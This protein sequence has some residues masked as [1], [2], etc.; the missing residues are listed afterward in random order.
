MIGFRLS[1]DWSVHRT[2]AGV[3]LSGG[4]DALFQVE[5]AEF[6]DRLVADEAVERPSVRGSEAGL[7]E[8]L[9]AAEIVI[10]AIRV[11]TSGAVALVG[12]QPP[13]EVRLSEGLRRVEGTEEA[14]LVV[15]VRRTCSLWMIAELTSRLEQLHL[16]VDLSFHH[17]VSIGPLVVPHQ[18]ACISCLAGRVTERWGESEPSADP[19]VA[20]NYPQLSAALVATE[21]ERA[22]AGDGSLVG[23]TASWNLADRTARRERLLTTAACPYC[24]P[25]Q[26]SGRIKL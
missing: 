11:G 4:D 24:R 6:L 1:P 22:I 5:A 21:I 8:K 20:R 16:F 9:V 17:T 12:D 13:W 2:D 19:A 15:V 18:T 14:D 10:P 7:F 3:V 23:W 25:W 26:A